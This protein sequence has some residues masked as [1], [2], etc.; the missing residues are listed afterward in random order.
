MA[1]LKDESYQA[2][3]R[4][5]LEH[6]PDMTSNQA[7]LY[8]YC[9]L[10]A[11]YKGD[12]KGTIS[13]FAV[14]I[15]DGVGWTTKVL[16]RVL[17]GMEAYLN[18]KYAQSRHHPMTIKILKFKATA[19]FYRTQKG[20]SNV[21]SKPV[22]RTQ[23]GDSNRTVKG[24]TVPKKGSVSGQYPDSNP[25]KSNESGGLE[26]PN[27]GI[28]KEVKKEKEKKKEIPP[29]FLKVAEHLKKRILETKQQKI[30][31][32][33]LEDWADCI[34]LMTSRDSRTVE[35]IKKLI[36]ECHDM[37][38]SPSTG[39]TWRNN[40]LSMQKLRQQWNEGKIWIGM[41]KKT[42]TVNKEM[43]KKYGHIK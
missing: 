38:P 34:R 35:D 15:A 22:Y 39:F 7:K 27:K 11:I 16:Y 19:D 31:D 17:Q 36:D 14:D 41:N 24:V 12:K 26:S 40:I 30:T 4:G 37:E 10:R 6:L 9:L 25:C 28:S 18:V 29:D 1:E 13:S 32:K 5:L 33:T 3:S 21:D 43:E 8:L 2:V 42:S 20:D 23:K